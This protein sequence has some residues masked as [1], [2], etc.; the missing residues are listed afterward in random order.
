MSRF[1]SFYDEKGYL[2]ELSLGTTTFSL[3]PKHVLV[4]SFYK[5]SWLFIHHPKRGIEFP[6]GKV[7]KGETVEEA[8]KRELFE[9]AGATIK[10]LHYVGQYK[11]NDPD[12]EFVKNIYFGLVDQ[13]IKKEN[14]L[15]TNGPV[16]MKDFPINV[17]GDGRFSF[18]MKDQVIELGIKE[19][20]QKWHHLLTDSE[21]AE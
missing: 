17:K 16:L 18:I 10:E 20:N 3:Q 12:G 2:V 6:G 9:E 7:E 5:G 21:G 15:E 1:I 19:V 8:A 14:Y 4:I 13:L 11:V